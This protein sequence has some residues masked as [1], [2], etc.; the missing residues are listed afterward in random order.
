MENDMQNEIR[1]V[2]RDE[3]GRIIVQHLTLCP[4]ATLDI[5]KRLRSL[6]LRFVTLIGFML[7][8]G[9]LGGVA[10]VGLSKLLGQ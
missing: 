8:S 2:A 7:G 3:A 10:G 9:V 4:F 1:A 5:E 6:E